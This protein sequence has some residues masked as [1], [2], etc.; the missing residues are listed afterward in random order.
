MRS[1]ELFLAG[2]HPSMSVT[3]LVAGV[4]AIKSSSQL[5]LARLDGTATPLP[6]G[7]KIATVSQQLTMID[8]A[9]VGTGLI[10]AG[11][12]GAAGA[13][14]GST[15]YVIGVPFFD[16]CGTCTHLM[17]NPPMAASI[18]ELG[19]ASCSRF[20]PACCDHKSYSSTSS[21]VTAFTV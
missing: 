10:T 4:T 1:V 6:Q 2:A 8:H 14:F 21:C 12:S 18:R 3:S 5:G 7:S 11:S 15:M 19:V 9:N 16:P 17:L 20:F 13:P